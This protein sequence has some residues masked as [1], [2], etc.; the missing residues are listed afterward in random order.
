MAYKAP[1]GIFYHPAVKSCES[2]DDAGAPDYRHYVEL[3]DGWV[4]P[5]G[6]RNEGGSSTFCHT[7]KDFWDF[8][9]VF[10]GPGYRQPSLGDE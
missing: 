4:M 7:V 10:V 5:R 2:A 6:H 8:E 1:K 3:N 9:P